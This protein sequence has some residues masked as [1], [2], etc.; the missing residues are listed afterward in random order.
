M[1]SASRRFARNLGYG[2]G[3]QLVVKALSFLFNIM[4]V[5]TLGAEAFGDY[6]A[7]NAYGQLFLFLADLGLST[8][9]VRAIAQLRDD[10][11]HEAH[12]RGLLADVLMLRVLLAALAAGLGIAL[13]SLSMQPTLFLAALAL[14][15]VSL[16]L[17]G[18]QSAAVM[19]LAGI[20][21]MDLSARAQMV[22]QVCF[23]LLGAFAL[24]YGLGYMGVIAGNL[25]AVLL[26]TVLSL[27][28]LRGQG[29]IPG[30]A[31]PARWIT[32]LRASAPFAVITL[33][34]GL[35]YRFDSVLIK[36]TLG[37][38]ATGQYNAAY[39]LIFNCVLF[40]NL[41]NTTLYPVLSR[42][43]AADISGLGPICERALRYLLV[44]ALPLTIGLFL[45][46]DAVVPFL[47]KEQFAPAAD[48]LRVLIWVV[49]LQYVSEFLGYLIL[50]TGRE[51]LVA[52]SVLLS[53][54]VNVAIN[55]WA[56]P[57]YG[58]QGAAVITVLTEAV[59][60][61]QYVWL[62]RDQLR[63]LDWR[64][65]LIRPLACAVLMALAMLALPSAHWLARALTGAAVYV[66]ALLLLRTIGREELEFVRGLRRERQAA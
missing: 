48:V 10:A 15:G 65:F 4:L 41:L 6:A 36:T 29:L 61:G 50:V 31:S 39:N 43:A 66:G 5:R 3:S 24:A 1:S 40:S 32:L 52:R 23:V 54:A 28:A 38:A 11:R 2:F 63:Q 45:L 18:V 37:S 58:V 57:R 19:A 59:L 62:L 7:V 21:R 12:L 17:Y 8:Y 56:V 30:R 64:R 34:L 51:R 26:L 44:V 16:L 60:V 49:P 20:E 27:R 9:A 46:A 55:L 35:S 25:L 42:Q 53:S 13:A 14:N 47:F 22:F 33:A